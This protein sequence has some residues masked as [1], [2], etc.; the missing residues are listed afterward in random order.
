MD[1]VTLNG[2][3]LEAFKNQG[4]RV[5]AGELILKADIDKIKDKVPSLITPVVFTN[6]EEGMKI[7]VNIGEN[8]ELGQKN[9]AE[10]G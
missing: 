1:T 7:S 6:L 3:G 9:I 5:K 4:D 8:V 2:E 10:V